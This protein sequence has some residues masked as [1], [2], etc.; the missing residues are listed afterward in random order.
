MISLILGAEG[1]VGHALS[2]KIPN[3]ILGTHE[4]ADI[5]KYDALFSMFS[6]HR[7]D[8][9]YMP[10]GI[11]NVD[12][13]EDPR[14]DKV[15]VVGAMQVA[16]MCDMFGA[17]FVFFS[18]SYVFDGVLKRPYTEQDIIAPIQNYGKQKVAV[19]LG[20]LQMPVKNCVII[21]TVGVFGDGH[22]NKSYVKQI[23]KAVKRG[24]RVRAPVDQ[25]MNPISSSD[26]V[27][28]SIVLAL[29]YTGIFHVAGDECMSK[30]YFAQKV[31]EYFGKMRLIEPVPSSKL[32]QAAAR[33]RMGC[34]DCSE[35]GRHGLSAPSFE[36]GLHKYLSTE[37]GP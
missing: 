33:P 19:E 6:E 25:Y 5:T 4:T 28:I 8:I 18:S 27:S 17:K 10:A 22:K 35:L 23:A 32:G 36:K 12:K 16:R 11:T 7:P 13:C 29:K 30:F 20:L 15:N 1:Q 31:A 9:V 34:L 3:A 37:Y 24:E 26:L 21:R 2:R 14:T